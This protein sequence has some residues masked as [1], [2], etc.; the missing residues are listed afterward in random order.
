MIKDLFD[1]LHC[2]YIEVKIYCKLFLYSY[3]M[4]QQWKLG[5]VANIELTKYEIFGSEHRNWEKKE[6]SFCVGNERE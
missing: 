2:L 1:S 4:K 6:I 3:D 5:R